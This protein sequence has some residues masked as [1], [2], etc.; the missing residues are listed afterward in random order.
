MYSRPLNEGSAKNRVIRIN[1]R[2]P[3]HWQWRILL[4]KKQCFTAQSLE[5]DFMAE[6]LRRYQCGQA[7]NP[8]RQLCAKPVVAPLDLRKMNP[9]KYI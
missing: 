3:S 8:T 9:K 6:I 7:I 2:R 1:N 5:T 4:S